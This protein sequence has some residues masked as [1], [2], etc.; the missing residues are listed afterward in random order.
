MKIFLVDDHSI[1]LE[2]IRSLLEKENGI[3][4][5]GHAA[6]A[7]E[8]L[9][10]LERQQVDLL[11]CDL[12]LPGM[13]GLSLIRQVKRISPN[14][15][16]IVLTMHDEAHIVREILREGVDGYLLK[17]DSHSELLIAIKRV[18]HDEVYLSQGLNKVLIS[19]VVDTGH[20]TY[21]TGREKEILKLLAADLSNKEIAA[22]LHISQRT[23]ETHRKNLLRK[24]GSNSVVG[25][26]NYAHAH[27]IL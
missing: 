8:A 1:L 16:I 12:S 21:L 9:S 3:E 15:K 24:T 22:K 26:I 5:A 19:T 27:K 6:S 13:N 7:E 10:F 4:V 23:V 2:G 17:R 18:R 25:L 14:S 11:I 20:G